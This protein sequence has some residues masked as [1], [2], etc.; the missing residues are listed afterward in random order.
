MLYY[1]VNFKPKSTNASLESKE[2]F[3]SYHIPSII[4]LLVSHEENIVLDHPRK[5]F[6]S[7]R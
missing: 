7:K 2:T 1:S 3:R 6:Y 4:I 5:R